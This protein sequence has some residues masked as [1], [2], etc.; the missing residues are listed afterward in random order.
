VRVIREPLGDFTSHIDVKSPSTR[1][2]REIL[3]LPTQA[4][5]AI[6]HLNNLLGS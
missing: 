3:A 5:F 6:S 4:Q 1:A 2:A